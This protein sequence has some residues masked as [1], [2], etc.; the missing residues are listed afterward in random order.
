MKA[1]TPFQRLEVSDSVYGSDTFTDAVNKAEN[2]PI[3]FETSGN[4]SDNL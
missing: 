4:S 1:G 3:R 2:L